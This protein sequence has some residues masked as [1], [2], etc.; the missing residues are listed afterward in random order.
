MVAAPETVT[1]GAEPVPRRR[2]EGQPRKK[3]QLTVVFPPE[4]LDELEQSARRKGLAPSALIRMWV[5][6]QLDREARERDRDGI[7]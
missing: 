7:A 1:V 2:D 4:T 3:S 6:Q 5:I